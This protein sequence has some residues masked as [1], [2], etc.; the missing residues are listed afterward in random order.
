MRGELN[1]IDVD[2][3]GKGDFV[4]EELNGKRVY[5]SLGWL[6]KRGAGVVAGILAMIAAITAAL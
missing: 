5:V 3:D 1:L 2:D 6:A 4:I